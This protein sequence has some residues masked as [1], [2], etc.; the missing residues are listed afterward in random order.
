MI[1]GSLKD[2]N[3]GLNLGRS[4]LVTHVGVTYDFSTPEEEL[5]K[6]KAAVAVGTD[7]IADASLGLRCR[8]TIKLLCDNLDVPV[9]ALP[10][11]VIASQYGQSELDIN[12]SKE[13]ILHVTEEVLNYGVKGITV[14]ASFKKKHLK[15][16]SETTRIFPFTSRMGNY[17]KKYMND[18]GHENPF[19][20]CFP[21]IVKLAKKYDAS[22][23]L[24]L[25]LRSPSITNDY[26]FDEL[27]KAEII[28][29]A[30]LVKM[31]N[32]NGVSVTLESGG[33][34]AIS[35]MED[36][37]KYVKETCYDVPLRVLTIGTDRGMGHDNVAGAITAGFLSRLGVELICTIT[38]AEHISQP[39]LKDIVESVINFRIALNIINPDM[40]LEQA[41]AKSRVKGGCHLPGVVKNVIDPE[42]AYAAFVER[43]NLVITEGD[44]KDFGLDECTMC[45]LSCPLKG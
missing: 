15:M 26:G 30:E 35:K 20:D 19:Y 11:Y 6:A 40:V 23:S 36:W 21:E 8:E 18:T 25:A 45:G 12:I 3:E 34:I 22:I 1:K 38:R 4:M 2:G 29:S 10:G 27:Y 37:Y 17:I 43:S 24:G 33:H 32:D 44:K 28:E 16:L 5:E 42:G 13:D 14:H 41:V 31:C 39:T 7:I 9:T